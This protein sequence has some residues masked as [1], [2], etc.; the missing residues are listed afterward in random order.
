MLDPSL[1]HVLGVKR[2]GSLHDEVASPCE[3]ILKRSLDPFSIVK[4]TR[5]EKNYWKGL[6]ES[7]QYLKMYATPGTKSN[8]KCV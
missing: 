6:L 4:P 8:A 1:I 3:A 2:Q 5:V 7:L